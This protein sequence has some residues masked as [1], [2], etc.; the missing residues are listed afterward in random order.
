MKLFALIVPLLCLAA[1]PLVMAQ[2][3]EPIFQPS[4]NIATNTPTP[5]ATPTAA[6]PAEPL[7][8]GWQ[9]AIG[10]GAVLAVAALLYGAIKAWRHANFFDRQYRFSVPPSAQLRFGGKRCGGK[11]GTIRF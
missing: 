5:S 7:P 4:H 11:M 6:P 3:N 8:L 2:S 10:I 1:S 9:I